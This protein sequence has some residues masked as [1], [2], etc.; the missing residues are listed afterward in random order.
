MTF[1]TIFP[2]LQKER[3]E[4]TARK[5]NRLRMLLDVMERD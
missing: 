4:Q 3:D 5:P 2:F 1:P